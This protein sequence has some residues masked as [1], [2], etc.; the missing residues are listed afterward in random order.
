[1]QRLYGKAP[2]IYKPVKLAPESTSG[3]L[4]SQSAELDVN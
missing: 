3:L 4:G 1:M 2:E